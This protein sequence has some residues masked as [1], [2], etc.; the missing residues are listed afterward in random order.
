[1]EN[2]TP[3]LMNHAVISIAFEFFTGS[4]DIMP[5]FELIHDVRHVL[6]HPMK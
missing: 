6:H 4:S 2:D 5:N 3:K 1:M